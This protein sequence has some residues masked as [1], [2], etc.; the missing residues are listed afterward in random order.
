[1]AIL[2]RLNN[3]Q[4][5]AAEIVDGPLLVLAGA[6]AGKTRVLTH[7]I[8]YL[9]EE[10]GIPPWNILAVTFTNKA[11]GEMRERV[12]LLVGNAAT[13]IWMGTFHSICARLLR[14]EANAFGI[15]ADFTIYDED[16]RL[17]LMRRLLKALDIAEEDLAPRALISQISRA[18]NAM[19]GPEL[20]ARE[21]SSPHQK[22]IAEIYAAYETELRRNHAFDFDD[23]LVKLVHLFERHDP[24]LAKYQQ[25][26]KYILIDEYQDTNRPQY[27]LTRQL[28]AGHHNICCVGDD[29]QSIYQFRG[30]DLRNI[31]D[32]ER[33]YPETRVVRLEQNYRSTGRILAAANAVI[34][35]NLDRKGKTLWTE[36]EAGEPIEVVEC[37][38]DRCEAR[39]VVDTLRDLTWKEGY[40]PEDA[41]V[42]YRT[43]A[44]SRA[45]EEELQRAGMDYVIIGGV[46]FYERREI[47]DILAYL[48]L[49]VNPAD[50]IS[51]VRIA[52]TPRRGIGAVSMERLTQYARQQ[53]IGL[54][55]ALDQLDRVPELNARARKNLESLGALLRELARL[56]A[57]VDLSTLGEEVFERT[58]YRRM[59]L[60]EGTPEAEGREQN[61]AQL[62]ADMTEFGQT[63]E[64][65]SLSAFLE[66]K[67]LMSP[68]DETTDA[69]KALTLMTLHS[70]KGLEFPL[71]FICGMEEGLFPTSRAVEESRD[72]PLA[73][74][75][76]RR[77]FY[78]GITRARK[79]LHLIR[80]CR[81]FAYGNLIE[82]ESSRFLDEV[83]EELTRK[84]ALR[85]EWYGGRPAGRHRTPVARP[86]PVR[87]GLH[88]EWDEAA[89]TTHLE[90]GIDEYVNDFLAV[91]KWVLHPSWG[92]G[93]IVSREGS[94]EDMKLSIRFKGNTL[95][96]V[97]VAYAQ[98]EPA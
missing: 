2:D 58:L 64:D 62:L 48:R 74:E 4:R 71:V 6:G 97:A 21:E 3:A 75:E 36:S 69:S 32:F 93:E 46:R 18:K 60:D 91:G 76:E 82:T 11:A 73:I 29:D 15:E 33:D 79:R 70:A 24:V 72:N 5:Q 52:N 88:Y 37:S 78:V 81:R 9:V 85:A 17:A 13:A 14:F 51:L 41:A 38:T 96:R 56:K 61:I 16:D 83:P 68:V 55:A 50:D 12:E 98:L 20:F 84:T 25:R 92:R 65:P 40:A 10:I 42:L 49:L 66:E 53:G 31:L 47:K 57:E 43:N 39:H 89:A 67:S 7:R 94:G 59:L 63:A 45:L 1:M 86:E 90:P 19:V 28:A 23:L 27:L 80:A 22:R 26:F 34:L 54:F 87:E 30:A 77:L 44:Q 95:K 8:A 35:N